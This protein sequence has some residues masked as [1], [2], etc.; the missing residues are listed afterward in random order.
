MFDEELFKLIIESVETTGIFSSLNRLRTDD[1]NSILRLEGVIN[2]EDYECVL[3]FELNEL[4]PLQLPRFYV[5]PWDGLGFIPHI[6]IYGT[7]CIIDLEGVV[8]DRYQ[9]V[10]L[11]IEALQKA[12]QIL[13]DGISGQNRRDFVEEFEAHWRRLNNLLPG[14][15]LLDPVKEVCRIIVGHDHP[16]N[17]LFIAENEQTINSFYNSR[18]GNGQLTI[19]NG[20]YVPLHEGAFIKPPRPDKDFWTIEEARQIIMSNLAPDKRQTLEA[21]L[22]QR[23]RRTKYIILNL[24]RYSVGESLFGFRYGQITNEHPLLENGNAEQITPL[25]LERLDRKFLIARGGGSTKLTSKR[26]LLVGCGAIGG[27]LAFE[28]AKAGISE[29]TLVDQDKLNPENTYRHVLGRKYW[30]KNKTEALKIALDTHFL[31]MNVQAIT[32]SVEKLLKDRIIELTNYDLVILATGNPTIELHIN[33]LVHQQPGGPMALFT[34]LEPLGIGGHAIL[35]NNSLNG[36]CLECLYTSVTQEAGR[37]ENR[38]AFA[39]P[40][41]S[42]G[43]ALSGCGSLYTPYGSMDALYTVAMAARLGINALIG[44]ELDNPLLSW[45]GDAKAFL[46]EGYHLSNRHSSSETSLI[47]NRYA[48]KNQICPICGGRNVV[49]PHK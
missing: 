13:R 44:N 9:P 1:S 5:K 21:L 24:P 45:K 11:V 2:L 14:C 25:L 28:L 48:Y 39:A 29:I 19:E 47:D 7:I 16:S 22:K 15:S 38:A 41:Q 31:Y 49:E 37:V 26:I 40:E 30:G 35:T 46:N 17:L 42:F 33:E 4:F 23:C 8:L 3:G 43:R 6:D 27:H 12:V 32:C 10:G 20:L 36:G 18:F 34:W